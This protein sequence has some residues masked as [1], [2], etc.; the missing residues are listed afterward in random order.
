MELVTQLSSLKRH[1]GELE[2]ALERAARRNELLSHYQVRRCIR[3][4]MLIMVV[5][6]G[7]SEAAGACRAR[8][9]GTCRPSSGGKSMFLIKLWWSI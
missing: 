9:G 2:I 1:V 5:R 7:E 4:H 6:A 3:A 8:T